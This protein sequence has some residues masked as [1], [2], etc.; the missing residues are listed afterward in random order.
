MRKVSAG[1]P[2]A[3]L[4]LATIKQLSSRLALTPT[5]KQP[6]PVSRMLDELCIYEQ[7]TQ[8]D[9]RLQHQQEFSLS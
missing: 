8:F 1:S 4:P 2:R 9:S 6:Y 7:L 3:H 5:T